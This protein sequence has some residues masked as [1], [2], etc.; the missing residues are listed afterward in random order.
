MSIIKARVEVHY[1]GGV[2][3][4]VPWQPLREGDLSRNLHVLR[5]SFQ[6]S[7]FEMVVEGLPDQKYEV[8]LLT[9]WRVLGMD[10]TFESVHVQGNWKVLQIAA[11]AT[12]KEKPDNA[13]YVRWTVTVSLG[14]N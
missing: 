3:V 5:T 6:N 2:S 1:K 13:G 12:L 7:R 11:P 9:P 10:G 4:D 14:S 8:R